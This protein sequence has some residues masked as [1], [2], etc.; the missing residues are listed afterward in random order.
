MERSPKPSSPTNSNV[1][2]DD[3]AVEVAKGGAAEG[4]GGPASLFSLDGD[5]WSGWRDDWS[6]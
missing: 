3:G 1:V 2:E 6:G 4:H 5:D